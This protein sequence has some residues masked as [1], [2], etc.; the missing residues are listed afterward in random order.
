[1]ACSSSCRT[2]DHASWGE[3]VRAKRLNTAPGD[4]HEY[5]Q[6]KDKGIDEYVKARKQGMQPASIMPRD[7]QIA[8]ALSDRFGEAHVDGQMPSA[9]KEL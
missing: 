3:C 2:K 1:M 6:R 8:N 9:L 4:V 7:V 5:N